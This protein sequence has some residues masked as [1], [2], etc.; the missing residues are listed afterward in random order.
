ME[1]AAVAK[2]EG[3]EPLGK[4]SDINRQYNPFT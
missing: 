4:H 2:R 3:P 1:A